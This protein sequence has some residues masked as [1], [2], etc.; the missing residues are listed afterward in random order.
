MDEEFDELSELDVLLLLVLL[1]ENAAELL[2]LP[3]GE[4]PPEKGH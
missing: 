4:G 1:D 2:A 3:G